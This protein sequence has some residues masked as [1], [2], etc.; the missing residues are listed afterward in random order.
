MKFFVFS[1]ETKN[2][3]NIVTN[4]EECGIIAVRLGAFFIFQPRRVIKV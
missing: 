2:I 1:F 3:L 4:P